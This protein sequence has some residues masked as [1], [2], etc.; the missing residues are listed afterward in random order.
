MKRNR[1]V[2][3][4]VAIII[5]AGVINTYLNK[6]AFSLA[7]DSSVRMDL[8]IGKDYKTDD[9]KS[10]AKEVLG[11]DE[12]LVQ[13]VETFND[14]AAITV[15]T[16]SDEQKQSLL[17]KINEKYETEIK[18]ED[19]A[20]TNIPHYDGKDLLNR[21]VVPMVVSAALIIVYLS[22]R[23]KKLGAIKV[24]SRTVLWSII[25]ALLYVSIISL[26]RIPVSFYT[27][28][29]GIVI[30]IITLIVLMNNF[31]KELEVK[32]I[33]DK[34]SNKKIKTEE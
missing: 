31:E 2:Y 13:D 17:D 23:Y 5:I 25:I 22:V 4:I 30:E 6:F 14:M 7:Y 26:A 21:Y 12:I 9:I 27:I 16:I 8:Y 11:T 19:I 28:P 10:I 1:V 24:S 33:E 29:L 3:V 20:I 15:R 34:K 32:K 18:I